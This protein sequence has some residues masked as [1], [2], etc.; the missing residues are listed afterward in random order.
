[1]AF[2]GNIKLY[3]AVICGA[4]T[5]TI[6]LVSANTVAMSVRERTRELAILR[7]LGYDPSEILRMVLGESVLIAL[8]GGLVGMGVTAVLSRLAA[9]GLG[10]WGEGIKF[11]W[12]AS[13][14][15]AGTA[16]LVGFAAALV[17]AIF[18]SRRNIVES[19]RFAG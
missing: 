13:L 11:Q 8:L 17:P 15:V 5:F 18:A 3:L 16:V 9:A 14:V 2:L 19:L 10:P 12:Q 1:M 4:I 6:L 7:T